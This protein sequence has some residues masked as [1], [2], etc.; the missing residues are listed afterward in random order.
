MG[1]V[2]VGPEGAEL[3]DLLRVYG[4]YGMRAFELEIVRFYGV[5]MPGP[6]KQLRVLCCGRT[7]RNGYGRQ[8]KHV[9]GVFGIAGH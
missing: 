3:V 6:G 2:S 4:L 5:E 9:L 1:V 7:R 8:S